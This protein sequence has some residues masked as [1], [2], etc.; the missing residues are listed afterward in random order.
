MNLYG[1]TGDYM[2][3]I[4]PDHL[5]R[6]CTNVMSCNFLLP[7]AYELPVLPVG[8]LRSVHLPYYGCAQYALVKSLSRISIHYIIIEG[9]IIHA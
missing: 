3:G 1:W 9:T 7:G 5:P 8:R 4:H 2:K 6:P